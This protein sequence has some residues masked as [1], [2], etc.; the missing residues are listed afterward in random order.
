MNTNLER[1]IEIS[2]IDISINELFFISILSAANSLVFLTS[3]NS[4]TI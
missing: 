2:S 4:L 3:E 1:L